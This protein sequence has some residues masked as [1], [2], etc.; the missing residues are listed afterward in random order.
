MT[1]RGTSKPWYGFPRAPAPR[2]GGRA[3]GARGRRP[4]GVASGAA[5]CRPTFRLPGAPGAP[6]WHDV[7]IAFTR[8]PVPADTASQQ[9][10]ERLGERETA[11]PQRLTLA[12]RGGR[13]P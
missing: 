3:R 5:S 4:R 9:E 7:D 1:P 11:A 8:D 13:G 6:G 2:R 12:R 10:R